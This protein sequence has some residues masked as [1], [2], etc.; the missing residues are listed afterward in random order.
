MPELYLACG[1]YQFHKTKSFP[2]IRGLFRYS[3]LC[4]Y[5]TGKPTGRTFLR[6]A[7]LGLFI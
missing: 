3:L 1:L 2:E 5:L 4:N 7:G 6:P